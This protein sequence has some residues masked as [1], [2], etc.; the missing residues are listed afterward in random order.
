M[1]SGGGMGLASP[2]L[3]EWILG[4]YWGSKSGFVTENPYLG[5]PSFW[6]AVKLDLINQRTRDRYVGPHA[7]RHGRPDS[8][9]GGGP[10]GVLTSAV[11]PSIT[12]GGAPSSTEG[13]GRLI[14]SA[15][16]GRRTGTK[17]RKRCPP[18]FHWNGRRCVSN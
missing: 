1:G 7:A 9:G 4:L 8:L 14:N 13:L 3:S 2:S 6:D 18:G 5:I 11:P 15:H 12:S 17:P 10:G 16:G